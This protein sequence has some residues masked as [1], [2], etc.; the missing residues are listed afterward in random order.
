[1]GQFKT[2]C[3]SEVEDFETTCIENKIP[4]EEFILEEHDIT[5]PPDS[6]EIFPINGFVTITRNAISRT[7]RTGNGTHW[8]VDFHDD[9]QLGIYKS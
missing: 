3:A 2:I 5:Q 1:M 6:G 7:Y 4:A 8:V 9:L